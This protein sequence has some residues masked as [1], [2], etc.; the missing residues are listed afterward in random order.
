MTLV[1]DMTP[2]HQTCWICREVRGSPRGSRPDP[3]CIVT[4]TTK[5][6]EKGSSLL[7]ALL[8]DTD[9]LTFDE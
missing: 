1:K 5:E 7:W 9:V 8:A 2:W 3:K 4:C 6:G